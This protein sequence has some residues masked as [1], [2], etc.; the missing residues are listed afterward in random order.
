MNYRAQHYGWYARARLSAARYAS[1][2]V[3]AAI[4]LAVF[5]A[6]GGCS[7]EHYRRTAEAWLDRLDA[8]QKDVLAIFRRDASPSEAK[9][10]FRRWRIF[11][12]AVAE[13][14]GCRGGDE[15]FVSQYLLE[16]SI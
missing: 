2:S 7:R 3:A 13:L 8:R 4:L 1:L 15:W 5:L 16:H 9:R 12:L 14:F 11:L 10:R 6:V